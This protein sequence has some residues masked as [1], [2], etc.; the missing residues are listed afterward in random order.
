[1]NTGKQPGLFF[2]FGGYAGYRIGAKTITSGSS[3]LYLDETGTQPLSPEPVS[4]EA[5]TDVSQEINRWNFGL[6]G[7]AGI[8]WKLGNGQAVLGV[9]FNYGLS[10][11]QS[12]PEITGRNRTGGFL[13]MLGYMINIAR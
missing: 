7:A 10:N 1:I 3:L 13:V 4:F 9:R 5:N 8:S 12:H 2:A 11:I 6:C